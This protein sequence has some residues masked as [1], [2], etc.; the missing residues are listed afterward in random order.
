MNFVK[1]EQVDDERLD[2]FYRKNEKQLAHLNEPD[3]GVFIGESELV[4]HRALDAGYKPLFFLI[5][6]NTQEEF[7]SIFQRVDSNLIV[8]VVKEEIFNELK[9][10]ILIKGILACFERKRLDDIEELLACSKRI[11]VLEEVENPTNV[12]AIF[13]NAAGLFADAVLLTSDACD[14]LYRRSIRVSMGNVFHMKWAFIDNENYMDILH[15]HGFKTVAFALK[16]NSID[17]EDERLKKEEK[18]AILMGSE[19][20]GLDEDTLKKSDYIVKINMNPNVD[21]LNVASASGIA[22]YELCK[23]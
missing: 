15:A 14:P 3:P 16:D 21:S 23:K 18:L 20:Y 12:G 4:I 6:E 17:L 11:V 2:I 13:R 10:F 1:I 22:L 9:G 7:E 8:Y 5:K 19:G